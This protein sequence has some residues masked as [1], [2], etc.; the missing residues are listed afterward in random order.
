MEIFL[1]Q[2][3]KRYNAGWIIKDLSTRIN[4]GSITAIR[5]SNGSGKST[6]L[7]LISG[8]LSVSKGEIIYQHENQNVS[9]NLIYSY[10]AYGSA[11]VEL[12]EE[13][14]PAE[15]FRHY[16]NFKPF[17]I[18]DLDEFL[19][20]CDFKK[21]KNKTISNFSSGMKQRLNLA[22]TVNFKVPL[23]L[24]DEPGSFLDKEKKGWLLGY[25]DKFSS[26][27]TIIIASNE[28]SDLQ[29]CNNSILLD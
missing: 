5:G 12:E 20:I 22:L 19:S 24:L 9:R 16:R 3:W 23:L 17:Y 18:E 7:Q 29:L 28:E 10:C 6:L 13:F 14:T 2:V 11:S 26:G 1:N 4:S 27:R 15:L 21:E 25:L 8:L